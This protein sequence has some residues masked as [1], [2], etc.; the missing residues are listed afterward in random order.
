[1]AAPNIG[2]VS[3]YILN[4]NKSFQSLGFS[5]PKM[6]SVLI[7]NVTFRNFN[8]RK[9]YVSI[10]FENK[11]ID[12]DWISG[13]FLLITK[14]TYEKI[15]GFDENIFMYSEDL[16]LG[17]KLKNLNLKNTVSKSTYVI[18][19]QKKSVYKK[20]M[21]H[22]LWERKKNYFYVLKKHNH[23]NIVEYNLIKLSSYFNLLTICIFKKLTS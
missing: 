7:D 1:M 13:C 23:F 12:V 15:N 14:R 8:F 2:S 20:G 11:W 16:D 9:K 6:S 3:S 19:D 10:N 4:K 17:Y 21:F 5:F 18:H 22:I